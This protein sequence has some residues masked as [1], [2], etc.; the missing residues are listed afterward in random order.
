MGRCLLYIASMPHHYWA[1][2]LQTACFIINCTS[3]PVLQGSCPYETLF[4]RVL[5]LSLLRVFGCRCYPLLTPYA[6]TKLEPRSFP[7]IFMGY[8]SHHKGYRCL[9]ISTGKS[10]VSRQVLFDEETFPFALFNCTQENADSLSLLSNTHSSQ[11]TCPTFF[12][13]S[14][15]CFKSVPHISN[16][17][18]TNQSFFLL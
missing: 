18:F 13:H 4:H 10:Y 16:S 1:D 15:V 7:C 14:S 17:T 8:N 5:D 6:K 11:A 3:T 2:A 12:S 9:N